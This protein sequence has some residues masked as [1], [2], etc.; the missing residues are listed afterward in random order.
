MDDP[1]KV[2]STIW[3]A[4][5]RISWGDAP[6]TVRAWGLE[7]GLSA[8][9][10]DDVIRVSMKERAADVRRRGI[11]E[12]FAGLGI[13]VLGGGPI[14]GMYCIGYWHSRVFALCG[15]VIAFGFIRTVRGFGW[16]SS[17]SSMRGSVAEMGKDI[18]S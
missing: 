11:N 14:A 18:F 15:V 7:Q 2:E 10:I 5:A 3:E 6:A 4:R 8:E 12:L 9:I 1:K 13:M 17:G 16:L